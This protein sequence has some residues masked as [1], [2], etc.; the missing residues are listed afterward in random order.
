MGKRKT[1]VKT[2]THPEQIKEFLRMQHW[3]CVNY[4]LANHFLPLFLLYNNNHFSVIDE[5][6]E[7][8]HGLPASFA[9][10]YCVEK[11]FKHGDL[12]LWPTDLNRQI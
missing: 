5:S 1:I 2:A 4:W 8:N 11:G 12:Y 6:P 9:Y 10:G 7:G 3:L